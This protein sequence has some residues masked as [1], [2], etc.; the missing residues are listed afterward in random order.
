[1]KKRL[2]SVLLIMAMASGMMTCTLFAKEEIKKENI[3]SVFSDMPN[4]WSTTALENAVKNGLLSGC[5]GQIMPKENMTRAQMAAVINRSFGTTEKVSLDSYTDVAANAWYYADMAKAVQMKTLVGSDNKLNPDSNITREEA[6][7]V[8]VRAFKLPDAAESVL[9]KFSDKALVSPWAKGATASIVMAGYIGG[10]NGKLN[11]KQNMTR[12]EFAQLMDNLLKRYYKK[13]GTYITDVDGNVMINVPGVTLKGMTITGDLIIGDGVG[14]GDV[15]LDSVV[16]KGRTVIRGGGVNSIKIIG[17]SDMQSMV[18]TKIDVKIRVYVDGVLQIG[19]IIVDGSDDVIVEGGDVGNI[20]VV[21]SDVTVTVTDAKIASITVE[22]DNCKIIVSGDSTV[23]LVTINGDNAEII[24]CEGTT[25]ENIIV[26]G[27]GADISGAGRVGEV[28]ANADNITVST[29]GT[30]VTA[31][32]GTTGIKAGTVTVGAGNTVTIPGRKS[33]KKSIKKIN[34][35]KLSPVTT[36]TINDTIT[37]DEFYELPDNVSV[38]MRDDTTKELAVTWEP[39]TVDTS[40]AGNYTFVGTLMDYPTF[41][42]VS[43]TL[44]VIRKAYNEKAITA[45]SFDGLTPAVVGTIDEEKKTVTLT[46]PNGTEITALVATFTNSVASTVTVGEDDQTSGITKNDFTDE[47][48]YT[49]TAEDGSTATY[50]VTVSVE[51]EYFTFDSE[52]GTITGYDIAGGKDVVIPTIIN[53]TT[54]TGIGDSAFKDCQLTSVII[55]DCVKSIGEYVFSGCSELTQIIVD[56]SNENYSSIDGVLFNKEKTIFLQYPIGKTGSYI[57]PNSVVSIGEY[58]FSGCSELTSVTIPDSV[59]IGNDCFRYCENLI[60]V[61]IG[62]DVSFNEEPINYSSSFKQAYAARGAGTYTLSG[63]TWTKT[64]SSAKAITTFSFEAIIPA[65]VGTIDE[66]N[67]TITLTVPNGTDVTALVATFT[68]LVASTV[69]VGEDV[70]TSGITKND[71]T[72]EVVYTVTAE[73]GSTATYT[74]TVSVEA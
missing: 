37:E 63:S 49:V 24:V 3:P 74:V 47:V 23:Q 21:A 13:S 66:E 51:A 73:D 57:I 12:A 56:G 33:S 59:S 45:Y 72:D 19:E 20:M 2:F 61:T 48:V 39:A 34:S 22:G 8:V 5:G 46:V 70:Q 58:A 10:S 32:E 53:C 6:F 42:G 62:S 25:I 68:N 41:K 43:L 4:D 50:T 67:K 7:A 44:T 28:E 30:K 14:D 54:V 65:V 71:F 35:S 1:M 31:A 64:L 11:P 16:V 52:T 15:I 29:R 40:V 17:D 60:S 18:I 36:S 69:S 26:N 9:D 27:N 38:T 55:P